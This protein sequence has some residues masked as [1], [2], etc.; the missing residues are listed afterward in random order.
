E[1]DLLMVELKKGLQEEIQLTEAELAKFT[2]DEIALRIGELR[3]YA[4]ELLMNMETDNS[5][6]QAKTSAALNAIYEQA[7]EQMNELATTTSAE[8]DDTAEVEDEE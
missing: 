5:D 7:L 6:E 3:S 1:K 8:P 4:D 2:Q